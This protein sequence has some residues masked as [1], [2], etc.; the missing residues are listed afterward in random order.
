LKTENTEGVFIRVPADIKADLSERQKH[1]GFVFNEWVIKVYR[2]L[3]MVDDL[4]NLRKLYEKN[5]LINKAIKEKIDIMEQEEIDKVKFTLNEKERF[6]LYD[7]MRVCQHNVE[8]QMKLFQQT[9]P[10]IITLEEY[11]KVKNKYSEGWT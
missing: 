6:A 3:V 8:K 1:H 7:C 2:Q 10:R 5:N 9:V 11:I 4:E